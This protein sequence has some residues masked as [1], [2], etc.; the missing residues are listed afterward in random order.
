LI[1]QRYPRGFTLIELLVVISIIALLVA[2]LLPAL[3]SAREAAQATVCQSNLKQMTI[4]IYSYVELNNQY[5]PNQGY[6]G[7]T[8]AACIIKE[9]NLS[10]VGEA[11]SGATYAPGLYTRDYYSKNR[12]NGIMKCP[13]ETAQYNNNWGGENSTSYRWNGG[14]N[15]GSYGLG[16]SEIYDGGSNAY[17]WSRVR[18]PEIL[19]RST[20]IVMGDG[21]WTDGQYKYENVG[22]S[23]TRVSDYHQGGGNF[24]W[25]DGHVTHLH[26]DEIINDDFDRRK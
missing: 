5:W 6:N 25:V 1:H 18:D 20:T 2:I 22:L 16:L 14:N 24:L 15:G 10:F 19:G 21:I 17:R 13:T 7:V 23:A 26:K 12:Q 9:L 3:S 11:T 4:G 8:F